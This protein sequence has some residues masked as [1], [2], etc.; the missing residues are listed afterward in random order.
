MKEFLSR[1]VATVLFCCGFLISAPSFA[2]DKARSSEHYEQAL[3]AFNQDKFEDAYI[4]LK[5]SLQADTDNLPAKILMGRVLMVSGYLEEAETEF[6]EALAAGADGNLV[7][8]PLGKTWLFLE[9]EQ[10]ILDADFRNLNTENSVNWR[11]IQATAN[12]NL[13]RIA[14]ARTQYEGA[15]RLDPQNTRVLN[16]LASLEFNDGQIDKAREY[17]DRSFAVDGQNAN[18]WRL[19][20]DLQLQQKQL[21][22]AISSLESGYAI[23][24]ENPV[25]NR[26]LVSAYLQKQDAQKAKQLLEEILAQTPDDPTASLLNAWLLAKSNNND[27]ASQHLESLSS[28]ISGLSEKDLS[29]KPELI[30]IAALSAFAQSKYEQANTLFYQYLTLVPENIDAIKLFAQTLVKLNR[31]KQ[32]LEAMQR[33]EREL[34]QDLNSALL[35]GN[36][37]VTNNKA[38]K[39]LE[40]I[41]RLKKQYPGNKR[42]E[43]L[44]IKTLIARGKY[45]EAFQMLDSSVHIKTDLN[46]ILTK[47]M[48]L[49]QTNRLEEATQVADLLLKAMPE[50]IDFINYKAAVLIKRKKWQEAE[51]LIKR[52]LDKKPYHYSA[53]FNLTSILSAR[54]EFEKANQIVTKLNEEL[55]DNLSALIMLARTQSELGQT[56]EAIVN[57]ERV[58]EKDI[59]NATAMEL[60]AR[61]H[62]GQGSGDKALRLLNS[63]VKN[64]PDEPSYQLSRAELYFVRNQQDRAI[65]EL[66]KISSMI[67]NDPESLGYH[68]RLALKFGQMNLAKQSLTKA[69]KL[70]PDDLDLADEYIRIHVMSGDNAQ[71]WKKL[72][73][74][75]GK[76][77]GNPRIQVLEGDLFIAD[78]KPQAAV[79]LYLQ[80]YKQSQNYRLALAK[81]YQLTQQKVGIEVFERE[82]GQLVAQYPDNYFQR[83]LLADF[84]V[85]IG[86]ADDALPHYEKLLEIEVLPNRIFILNN[87]ANIYLDKD[88]DKAKTYA[89]QAMNLGIVQAAVLDTHGWIKALKG[90]YNEALDILRRAHAMDSEDPA[91]RYHLGYTLLKLGRKEEARQEL[92]FALESENSFQEREDARA[93]LDSI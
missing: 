71:A 44:E 1:K 13:R 24:P 78:G 30:Y 54:G 27:E 79:P 19:L 91:V 63:L 15:L 33:H 81:L 29:D 4:H 17:L 59:D 28:N 45:D 18:T 16:A 89:E 26:S 7:V 53:R 80:A 86:K 75:K 69:T 82:I 39:A 5:N 8:D 72:S 35:L 3:E 41:Y 76:F 12:F 25:L 22:Q 87:M 68:S 77:A 34:S 2:A 65:R 64:A 48:L 73:Q 10:S 21:D 42:V 31:H 92:L 43:L 74:L 90:E 50:N 66:N 60:L 61:L 14:A 9:K 56:E 6:E 40:L 46:F 47:S 57:L 11:I 84:F 38:F 62:V 67:E 88:I 93:L 37:Y 20:G 85:N 49:L 51:P 23:D 52:V 58:L 55:P 36:L 83:S 70:L 32:A